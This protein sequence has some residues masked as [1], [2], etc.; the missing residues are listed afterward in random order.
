[1]WAFDF[2]SGITLCRNK[3]NAET[4]TAIAIFKHFFER[5]KEELLDDETDFMPM[6]KDILDGVSEV[7]LSP[8]ETKAD[9]LGYIESCYVSNWDGES[10]EAKREFH[11]MLK[12]NRIK[13]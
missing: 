3:M 13:A 1:M 4:Q 10:K 6:V 2:T 7:S 12:E 5:Y 8:E 9:V 11:K